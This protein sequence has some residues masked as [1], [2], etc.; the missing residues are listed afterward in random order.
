MFTSQ[1]KKKIRKT[2]A[3]KNNFVIRKKKQKEVLCY[4]CFN[5]EDS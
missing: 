2:Y 4:S 3:Y 1:F 5:G